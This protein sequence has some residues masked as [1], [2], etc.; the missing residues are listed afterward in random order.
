MKVLDGKNKTIDE[1]L[2]IFEKI[3]MQNKKLAKTL[4]ILENY[5]LVN[6]DFKNYYLGAGVVN[7]TVFNYY[8]GFELDYGIK[9]FDIFYFDS[10]V[11]YEKEDVII[12]DLT[13]LLKE[14][15]ILFDVKNQARVHIWYNEKYGANDMPYHSVEES[16]SS[17]GASVCIG[18]RIEEGKLKVFCPYGLNDLFTMTIRPV[19]KKFTKEQ[20]EERARRWKSKWN[21]LNVIEW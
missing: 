20:Y 17:L 10:D 5:A 12:K 16:I 14:V 2:L 8:H 7:Q 11:S 6:P 9:D 13:T 18:V 19:K 3:I 1:Q 15:D 21:K 4:E